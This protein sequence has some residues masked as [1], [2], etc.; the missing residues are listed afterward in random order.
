[1]LGA[2]SSASPRL[3]AARRELTGGWGAPQA[4]Q[5]RVA[6]GPLLRANGWCPPTPDRESP[7]NRNRAA[8]PAAPLEPACS[9]GVC[10][11]LRHARQCTSARCSRLAVSPSGSP[12]AGDT[13]PARHGGHDLCQTQRDQCSQPLCKCVCIVPHS[14]ALRC[15][16]QGGGTGD[17]SASVL[18]VFF[19]GG[20]SP[21][22]GHPSALRPVRPA[23]SP[24]RD[25]QRLGR[26]RHTLSV[27]LGAGEPVGE[28]GR[29]DEGEVSLGLLGAAMHA[30]A[31][32]HA[33]G[34][35]AHPRGEPLRGEQ[36]GVHHGGEVSARVA[37]GGGG[38]ALSA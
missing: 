32:V 36:C 14:S 26:T 23:S 10:H 22:G 21:P 16:V 30:P 19:P 5:E 24:P 28:T 12:R 9:G 2:S 20:R 7:E 13:H 15:G 11:V 37:E 6:A 29:L 4:C 18:H 1:M 3:H 33:A 25:E 38:S 35:G 34:T 31:R 8:R 27:L 17:A